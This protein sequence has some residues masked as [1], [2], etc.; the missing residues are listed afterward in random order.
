MN[1]PIIKHAAFSLGG[2]PMA[3][4]WMLVNCYFLF[5]LTSI[6]GL[7]GSLF[8]FVLTGACMINLA[9]DLF[10][11]LVCDLFVTRF[12]RYRPW[13]LIS[14]LLLLPTLLSFFSLASKQANKT[15]ILPACFLYILSILLISMWNI[16]FG[17][18]HSC[19]S[20]KPKEQC[21]LISRRLCVSA[22]SCT[23]VLGLLSL[24]CDPVTMEVQNLT[25]YMRFHQVLTLL[26]FPISLFSCF[27]TREMTEAA[28]ASRPE[29]KNLRGITKNNPPL[30]ITLFGVF[31]FGFLNYG[32]AI[33]SSFYFAY[34][35][36]KPSLFLFYLIL[37]G[38]TLGS[39]ALLAQKLLKLFREKHLLCCF[40]YGLVLVTGV[41]LYLI[42]PTADWPILLLFLWIGTAGNGIS[43]AMLCSMLPDIVTNTQER[44]GIRADGFIYSMLSFMRKLGGFLAPLV[45]HLLLSVA[46]YIPNLEQ[47]ASA[48]NMMN[49]CMNLIPALI[50]L[51]I[52]VLL[53]YYRLNSKAK[54]S[55]SSPLYSQ[56]E[57]C[58]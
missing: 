30:I 16:P 8:L 52:I 51:L 53:Q 58:R 13:M 19:I 32:Q 22:L 31:L 36:Q 29:A 3:L 15:G 20:Q 5:Y 38:C 6:A 47:S 54:E 9:S 23:L 57:G 49:G 48:F 50:A 1:K 46:G 55:L 25:L 33:I 34:V 17:G 27:F 39:T 44:T 42:T 10:M 45:L 43:N 37:S 26:L 21:G 18:L 24:L 11:G 2:I 56:E 12:G 35:V 40:G 28:K 7:S 14:S 41:L 4:T